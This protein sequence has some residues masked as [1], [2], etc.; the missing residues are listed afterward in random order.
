MLTITAQ[1]TDADSADSAAKALAEA[2]IASDHID[3][4]TPDEGDTILSARVETEMVDAA[5]AIIQQAGGRSVEETGTQ[6]EAT[7]DVDPT[8]VE[9]DEFGRLR[10]PVPI[11]APIPR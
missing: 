8:D 1:F 11:I 9:G 5:H 6:F 4:E 3:V 7:G 2:G 10:E